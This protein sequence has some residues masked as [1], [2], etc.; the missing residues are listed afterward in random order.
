MSTFVLSLRMSKYKKGKF[1]ARPK[2]YYPLSEVR[3]KIQS[4][5]VLIHQ[6][7][8]MDALHEFGWGAEEI[9]NTYLFFKD[10]HFYKKEPSKLSTLLIIDYY[11]ARFNGE[12]IYTHFYITSDNKTLVINSFKKDKGGEL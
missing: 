10:H 8:L 3:D 9:L 11:K 2:S 4:G 12:D 5:C 1:P 7:A 6:N